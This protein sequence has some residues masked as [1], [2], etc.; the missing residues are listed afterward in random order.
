MIRVFIA[1][2][3][4]I[5]R[6]GLRQVLEET[7]RF[8]VVGEA[9]NGRQ[10]LDATV[11]ADADVLLLD[12]S[13]PRVQGAEVLKRV[14]AQYPELRVAILSMYDPKQFERPLLAAGASVYLSK[15]SRSSDIVAAV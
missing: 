13:L 1:D 15:S 5:V 8:R 4:D 7:G 11:L 12:L 6:Q 14:R 2:D 10:V 9:V 3:H